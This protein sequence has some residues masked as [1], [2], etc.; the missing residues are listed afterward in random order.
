VLVVRWIAF[1]DET[2][3]TVVSRL[4]R[5]GAEIQH[6]DPVDAALKNPGASLVIFPSRIPGR[7]L[8]AHFSARKAATVPTPP[9][10]PVSVPAKVPP[11]KSWWRKLVA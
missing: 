10:M 7:L 9:P 4:R 5:G 11:P 8:I 1:D 2:A 6:T 3:E